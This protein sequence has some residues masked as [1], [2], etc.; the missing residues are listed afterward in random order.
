MKSYNNKIQIVFW[1]TESIEGGLPEITDIF[2]TTRYSLHTCKYHGLQN[3]LNGSW[4]I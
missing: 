3:M 4:D 1:K 2:G